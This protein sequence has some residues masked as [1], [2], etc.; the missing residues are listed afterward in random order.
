[1]KVILIILMT[2][3]NSGGGATSV[4][5]NSMEACQSAS[6]RIQEVENS[7]QKY[8]FIY[9]FCVEKGDFK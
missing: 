7:R 9:A 4:E 6:R 5:F 3:W 1:M 8:Q 2:V